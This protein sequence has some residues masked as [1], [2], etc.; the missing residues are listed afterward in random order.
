MT[1][2]TAT[3]FRP[4]GVGSDIFVSFR[5]LFV[6][7]RTD[8]LEV[9]PTPRRLVLDTFQRKAREVDPRGS[10]LIP[11]ERLLGSLV[12]VAAVLTAAGQPRHHL[13]QVTGQRVGAEVVVLGQRGV[14]NTAL[15]LGHWRVAGHRAILPVPS[16][17]VYFEG[18]GESGPGGA[19]KCGTAA[20]MWVLAGSG[21]GVLSGVSA[22]VHRWSTLWLRR[23]RSW[24]SRTTNT[25]QT[26]WFRRVGS[27]PGSG[28]AHRR[29]V[30]TSW[31]GSAVRCTTFI[32]RRCLA[33]LTHEAGRP[34]QP[35]QIVPAV[36]VRGEPATNSPKTAND[37]FSE[38]K[39]T[40]GRH[41]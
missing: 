24:R 23:W 30:G 3:A 41:R 33:L 35:G 34:A 12:G 39:G 1:C 15:P 19:I 16:G 32:S 37:R 18:G 31:S 36:R 9:G 13:G 5:T 25:R 28:R 2:G 20:G 8:V 7:F 38:R 26:T 40:Y 14:V 29:A 22:G 4:S 17:I 27:G 10:A 11:P 21:T 6:R